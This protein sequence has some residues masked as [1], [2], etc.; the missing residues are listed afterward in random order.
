MTVIAEPHVFVPE[1]VPIRNGKT[2]KRE[3]YYP[4]SDGEP[5]GETDKHRD[6]NNYLVEALKIHYAHRKEDVYVSGDNFLYYKQGSPRR[7]VS[8]DVYVVFGVPMRQRNSFKSWEEGDHLP[9][10]V[11]EVTSAA[12]QRADL[13]RKLTLYEKTLRVPE[14]LLY[15]PD[16]DY[17]SPPIAGYRL[18]GRGVYVPI[19]F[20]NN[21]LFSE[22]LG[23]DLTLTHNGLRLFN[24][25]TNEFY[26]TPAEQREAE[27]RA[28]EQA[29]EA[30]AQANEATARA[31]EARTRAETAEAENAR[32]RA[33]IAVLQAQALRQ[34]ENE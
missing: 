5:M 17:I 18:N 10:V 6:V 34:S 32:L 19:P 28:R 29:N 8:P 23:L 13:T 33:M 1:V 25:A 26:P 30:T 16:E 9:S 24:P 3:P 31:D 20:N 2:P 4:E 15:D 14:Y 12:T 22:Q 21:R 27:Y 7:F 11:I